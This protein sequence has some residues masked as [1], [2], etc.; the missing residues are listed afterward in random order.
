MFP[1][2]QIIRYEPVVSGVSDEELINTVEVLEKS[3]NIMAPSL[4]NVTRS[5]RS[6]HHLIGRSKSSE[7]FK[8][9]PIRSK[10]AMSELRKKR[11]VSLCYIYEIKNLC[12]HLTLT[13]IH[14][15]FYVIQLV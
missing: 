14:R 6:G 8:F 9:N 7:I 1:P 4:S 10:E 12:P 11:W 5:T 2:N 13:D 3:G 15:N